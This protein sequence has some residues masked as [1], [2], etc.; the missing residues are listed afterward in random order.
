MLFNLPF[1]S[2]N[3]P[4]PDV[5]GIKPGDTLLLLGDVEQ[6]IAIVKPDT[7]QAN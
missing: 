1:L 6:G 3:L 2:Y 4:I 5:F 7:V